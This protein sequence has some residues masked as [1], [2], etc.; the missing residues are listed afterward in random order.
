[1]SHSKG[2]GLRAPWWIWLLFIIIVV[3]V[4]SSTDK[5]ND[6]VFREEQR[7]EKNNDTVFRSSE[8][9]SSQIRTLASGA[10]QVVVELEPGEWSDEVPIPPGAEYCIDYISDD[11]QIHYGDGTEVTHNKKFSPKD[12]GERPGPLSFRSEKGGRV[13]VVYKGGWNFNP[14]FG[15]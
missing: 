12:D 11:I 8:P 14:F 15:R 2:M 1:M 4:V 10:K 3:I 13:I 9:N 6:T 7:K 5:N